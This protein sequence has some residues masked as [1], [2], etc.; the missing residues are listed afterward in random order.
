MEHISL[1]SHPPVSFPP[2]LPSSASLPCLFHQFV[3]TLIFLYS[4]SCFQY[5]LSLISTSNILILLLLLLLLLPFFFFF[6]F[7]LSSSLTFFHYSSSNDY[8]I[9]PNY[10]VLYSVSFRRVFYPLPLFH[11]V[12]MLY[13]LFYRRISYSRSILLRF[14]S[15]LSTSNFFFLFSAF[16][17]LVNP[18]FQEGL[19]NLSRNWSGCVPEN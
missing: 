15:L 19:A 6:F 14:Y 13:H 17:S 18:P 12:F 11:V 8:L 1:P 16:P 3:T 5:Q 4:Q 10:V 2:S 9:S 7:L